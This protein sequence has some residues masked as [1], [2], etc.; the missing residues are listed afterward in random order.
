MY[1]N[2]FNHSIPSKFAKY[3][4]LSTDAPKFFDV[5]IFSV[6]V[7]SHVIR[8]H[9]DHNIDRMYPAHLNFPPPVFFMARSHNQL[10]RHPLVE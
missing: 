8:T 7:S 5:M 4:F 3:F 1:K 2:R 9:T 10:Y 6:I